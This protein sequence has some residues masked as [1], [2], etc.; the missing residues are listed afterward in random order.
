M[1]R[2]N[3]DDPDLNE[4]KNLEKELEETKEKIY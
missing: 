1:Y 3:G 4:L 2:S